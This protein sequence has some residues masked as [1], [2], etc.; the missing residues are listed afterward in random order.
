MKY[1]FKG[2]RKDN[3]EWVEGY[4]IQDIDS[5]FI[6]ENCSIN[7]SGYLEGN[8]HEIDPET[9]CRCTG[10]DAENGAVWEH[11]IIEF[12]IWWCDGNERDSILRGEVVY[13]PHNMSFQLRGI[14]NQEWLRHTGYNEN[15]NFLTPFSEL[16]FTEADIKILGN[17]FDNPEL[18][19]VK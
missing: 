5:V 4:L 10:Y 8:I 15:D 18:L 12:T 1:L 19:E 17:I 13:S 6:V 9:I 7:A 11:E 3:N 16:N 14:R 2:K